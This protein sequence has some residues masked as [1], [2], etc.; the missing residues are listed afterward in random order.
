M[1]ELLCVCY[2]L[3]DACEKQKLFSYQDSTLFI[4]GK[5]S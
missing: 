3:C 1:R 5:C 2:Y 4:W